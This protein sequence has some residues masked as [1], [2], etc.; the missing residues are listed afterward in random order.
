MAIQP[1]PKPLAGL[2]SHPYLLLSITALLWGGNVVASKVLVGHASPLVV[3]FLRWLL[4]FALLIGFARGEIA[5]ALPALRT[6]WRLLLG[7]GALGF[8]GFNALFYAAAHHTQ[9]VNI[10]ILQG[11]MP[12]VVMLMALAVF[13]TPLRRLEVIGALTTILG[14]LAVATR[15][16]WG[17]LAAFSFNRGDIFIL[18]ATCLYGSYTVMLRARPP[19]S[20]LAYMFAVAFAA[21]LTSIPLLGYE[22]ATGEAQWPDLLGWLVVVYIAVGPSL[23]SQIAYL[24]SIEMIGPARASLFINLA[25]VLGAGLSAL[26]LGERIGLIDLVALGLVLGGIAV[27]ERGKY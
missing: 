7:L 12:V 11:A 21:F 25:P 16:E 2:F 9:G 24:R 13:R 8:T 17:R 15:G 10:A 3:V 22:M 18:I 27:A 5:A 20:A 23:L 1:R 14:V 26:L 19:G 4:V 6:K